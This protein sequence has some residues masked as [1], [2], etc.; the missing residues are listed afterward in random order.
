MT[1]EMFND[2]LKEKKEDI[3]KKYSEGMSAQ[4]IAEDLKTKVDVVKDFIK[5][6]S[7]AEST[8]PNLVDPNDTALSEQ[9][10]RKEID[11]VDN[12]HFVMDKLKGIVNQ[13]EYSDDG[14]NQVQLNALKPYLEALK[15]FSTITQWMADRRIK[16]EEM[17]RNEIITQA[18]LEELRA[19]SPDFQKRVLSR[20]DSIKSKNKLLL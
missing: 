2:L 3:I 5:T 17:M 6:Y 20:I 7:K 4:D 15:N 8:T 9:K 14:I 16:I 18:I 13:L 19:E 12:L 11:I 10:L 1:E